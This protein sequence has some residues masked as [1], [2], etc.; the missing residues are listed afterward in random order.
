MGKLGLAC[1]LA[2]GLATAACNKEKSA[3]DANAPAGAT[4]TNDTLY[5]AIAAADDLGTAAKLMKSA[6]LERAFDGAGSYTVFAP[7]DGAFAGL[8]AEQRSTLESEAGRPQLISL[9]RA[10]VTTG[11]VSRSDLDKGLASKGGTATLASVSGDPL[12]I[13]T[14]GDAIVVGAGEDAARIVGAPIQ[15]KN[16]VIYRIDRVIPPPVG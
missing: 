4:V 6:G 8:P 7:V 12:T 2:I 9:L 3:A 16:G 1:A 14:Q 5:A 11:Y 15:A 13:R 10:H